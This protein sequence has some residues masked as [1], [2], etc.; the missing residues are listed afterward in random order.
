MTMETIFAILKSIRPDVD[1][2]GVDDFFARGM[3]DSF[4]LTQLVST[5]EERFGISIDGADIVPENFRSADAIGSLLKKYG[6][7]F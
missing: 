6:A 1:F 4:D 2:T 5:L 3:L 7:A